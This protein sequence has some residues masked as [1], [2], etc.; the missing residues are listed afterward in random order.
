MKSFRIFNRQTGS[1]IALVAM[2]AAVVAPTIVSAAQLT[3][4]SVQLS[5]SSKTATDVSYTVNFTSVGAA[6]AVIVNFCDDTPLIGEACNPPAGLDTTSVSTATSGFTATSVNANTVK[7]VGTVASASPISIALD[8]INNPSAVGPIYAR[9]VTYVA[10]SDANSYTPTSL[11]AN[12]VDTG[13]AAM[14]ITDS[15]GV[16]AAVLESM[17][18]CVSGAV[19]AKDC[20]GASATPPTLKLGETTGS[21]VALSATAVSHG[22]IYTQISTN[23]VSGAVVR[24]KSSALNCGGLVRAGAPT[25]CDILPTQHVDL[26]AGTATFGVKVSSATS[27]TGDEANAIG[28]YQPVSGSGYGTSAYALNYN[29]TDQSTG[30]TSP[31]GD[32]FLDTNNAPVNNK[33]VTLTFGAS[34][35]NS[36]PAGLYSA[37]L[38]LIATGKF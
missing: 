30:V 24:L 28:A 21:I 11:G 9:I 17:V 31:Y 8:H 1:I 29:S 7:V 10:G 32:P 26:A 4:R 34:I 38:G 27:T 19:I 25:S 23:A 22:D 37:N 12:T 36:T 2:V 13:S 20:V 16:N 5:N 35:S 6:G 14:N 15:I 18:F 3:A 33:N